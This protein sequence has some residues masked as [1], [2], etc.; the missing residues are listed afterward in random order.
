MPDWRDR[1]VIDPNICH[2]KACIR[3]TRIPISLILD[4][5][6]AAE[7]AAS[8]SA[9][10]PSLTSEDVFSALGYAAAMLDARTLPLPISA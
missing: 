5:L 3:G 10:Y 4:N 2:G 9:A 8:I 7:T 6:A 1:V